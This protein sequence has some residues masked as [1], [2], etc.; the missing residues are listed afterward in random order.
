M[1]AC[2][3]PCRG[4]GNSLTGYCIIMLVMVLLQGSRHMGDLAGWISC[5]PVTLTPSG[6][7]HTGPQ[8]G[9]A[10]QCCCNAPG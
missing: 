10:P 9:G 2:L 1:G 7:K 4:M 8:A 3:V 5:A 6:S